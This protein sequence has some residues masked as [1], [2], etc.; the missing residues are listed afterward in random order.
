VTSITLRRSATDLAVKLK[1]ASGLP[2][3]PG[4]ASDLQ[5]GSVTTL[6][7]SAD[8]DFSITG[9]PPNQIL[10]LSLPRG[11]TGPVGEGSGGLFFE[12]RTAAASATIGTG[13]S[14]IRT[15]G[16]SAFGDG[17]HGLYKRRSTNPYRLWQA[18]V[19]PSFIAYF[20]QFWRNSAGTLYKRIIE[21]TGASATVE[22]THTTVGQVVTG[23]DGYSWK[24]LALNPFFFR[25]V[26]R[27]KADFTTDAAD[28]G[29][30]ELVPDGGELWIEQ[31]GGK[32]DCVIATPTGT[33]NHPPLM[34]ALDIPVRGLHAIH[35][36][37]HRIKCR[38]GAYYFSQHIEMHAIAHIIGAAGTGVEGGGAGLATAWY[39]PADV[40]GISFQGND[41]GGGQDNNVARLGQ[42]AGSC[43]ESLSLHLKGT[44]ALAHGV[45]MRAT[46]TCRNVSIY[47]APGHG[48]WMRGTVLVG[49][50]RLGNANNWRI[51]DC[52]AQDVGGDFLKTSGT[53]TNGGMCIGFVTHGGGGGVGGCGVN[54]E[55]S[56]GSSY[57]A[58]LQITGY[59]NGGVYHAGSHY[60][61]LKYAGPPPTAG[62]N[63]TTPG[64]D[65]SVWYFLRSGQAPG[66]PGFPTWSS[67]GDYS[68]YKLPIRCTS[69][70]TIFDA[71]YVETGNVVSHVMPP[72]C[73]NGGNAGL[74]IYSSATQAGLG[75]R[76]N[77]GVERTYLQ[78]IPG[79]PEYIAN[80][81][82]S[83]VGFG[84]AR[85]GDYSTG[86]NI[87]QH[88]RDLDG[89][90]EAQFGYFGQHFLQYNLR[91]DA[92]YIWN[93]T[94]FSNTSETFGRASPVK[95]AIT[96][97]LFALNGQDISTP[98]LIGLRHGIPTSGEAAR[99]ETYFNGSPTAGG[100]LFWTCTTTGVV[101]S[102]AVI[103]AA[104]AIDA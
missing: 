68:N 77:T 88:M 9:T 47:G 35:Y 7:A 15:A 40:T 61:L 71:P 95:Y 49:D 22:P 56:I 87:F 31:L 11:L 102:T 69:G 25:S 55:S 43:L 60:Q 66:V 13:I 16:F 21:D 2:G 8:A 99:G 78:P 83:F 93:I 38:G 79:S 28:G 85:G 48:F 72:A 37:T 5:E 101:G 92:P 18:G 39:F 57:Y 58:G 76:V 100:K 36:Q 98:R 97:N 54:D 84:G 4:E 10:N 103:K 30:W 65:N 34:F 62:A 89:D 90:V 50:E 86:L 42:S 33:D 64:T 59:G 96:Y 46:A 81:G 41:T 17:G 82:T 53:D 29:W 51:F 20:P 12:T 44:S 45:L 70:Y 1:F 74:T 6:D 14:A 63:L 27:L 3:V 23:A 19:P 26:D 32:A 24:C 73:V 52:R 67:A 80:G 104:G 75:G 91:P 94:T